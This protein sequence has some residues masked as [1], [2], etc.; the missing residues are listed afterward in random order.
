LGKLTF[1]KKTIP[2]GHLP[3]PSVYF[4]KLIESA[5]ARLSVVFGVFEEKP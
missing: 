5:D 3:A 4:G 2:V 1:V